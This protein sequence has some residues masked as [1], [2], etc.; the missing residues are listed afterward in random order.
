[1]YIHMNK[2]W[3]LIL[4]YKKVYI[5]TFGK[6]KLV[7]EKNPEKNGMNVRHGTFCR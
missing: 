6:R 2:I 7:T 4:L 1:M 3:S 5:K